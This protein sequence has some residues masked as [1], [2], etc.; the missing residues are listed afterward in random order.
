MSELYDWVSNNNEAA[1]KMLCAILDVVSW[2]PGVL[3]QLRID[4]YVRRPHAERYILSASKPGVAVRPLVF[5][6]ATAAANGQCNPHAV[7]PQLERALQF[8][9]AVAHL[10]ALGSR[11][12]TCTILFGGACRATLM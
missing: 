3:Q 6:M 11:A 8:A 5:E 10:R 1:R 2:F 12:G 4:V 9:Q 7:G